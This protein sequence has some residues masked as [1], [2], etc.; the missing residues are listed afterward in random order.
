M[1]KLMPQMSLKSTGWQTW[2]CFIRGIEHKFVGGS[3]DCITQ[4][5]EIYNMDLPIQKLNPVQMEPIPAAEDPSEVSEV[6]IRVENATETIVEANKPL[7][8]RLP[9]PKKPEHIKDEPRVKFDKP[10]PSAKIRYFESGGT[11]ID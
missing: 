7:T 8:P 4:A 3:E 11:S 5:V 10:S 1:S 6:A 9:K 2:S